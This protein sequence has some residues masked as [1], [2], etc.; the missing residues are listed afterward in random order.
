MITLRKSNQDIRQAIKDAGLKQYHIAKQMNIADSQFSAMLRFEL[1][2][3]EKG[4]V[5][6]AIKQ[7]KKEFHKG[8]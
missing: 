3:D 8:G 4:R 6:A 1:G 2:L 7:A 5:F